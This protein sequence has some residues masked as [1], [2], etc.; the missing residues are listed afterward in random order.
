M[1]VRLI[2]TCHGLQEVRFLDGAL[3]SPGMTPYEVS[4]ARYWA[5]GERWLTES[6]AQLRKLIN[7]RTDHLDLKHWG[8]STQQPATD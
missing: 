7:R 1:E 8:R 2:K 3:L 5:R 6:L 4:E